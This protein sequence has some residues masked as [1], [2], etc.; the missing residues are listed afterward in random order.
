MFVSLSIKT[1]TF[2]NLVLMRMRQA[3]SHP[4][5]V[6]HSTKGVNSTSPVVANG[7]TDCTICHETA[8]ER[9]ISTCCN[10]CFCRS[11]VIEYTESAVVNTT[12]CPHCNDPLS[13]DLND[14]RDDILDDSTLT[15]KS[16]DRQQ[17]SSV[18]LPSLKEL[19][20]V[21]TGSILRKIDLT[22]FA[23]SSKIENLCL[24][25]V[26]MRRNSPG[27]KAIV[28]SQFVNM[29]D[30]IR[31]RLHSDAFLVDLGLGARSIHGG[32]DAKSR[33]EVLKEFRENS[34]VRV[35]L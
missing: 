32:M 14:I 28:F 13:I 8:T 27:S 3:V 20:H 21:A 35:L 11:C 22:K 1:L 31:W 29:L 23:T 25:L 2:F 26:E 30:L 15:I 7:S 24:E 4:Y 34:S 5:L 10:S 19:P 18:G 17:V 12:N 16:S 33:D 9:V 6:I